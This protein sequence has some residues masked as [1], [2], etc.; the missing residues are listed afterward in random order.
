[1]E[2]GTLG[3]PPPLPPGDRH[4]EFVARRPL[5]WFRQA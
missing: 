1:M 3:D 4:A 2:T 5:S